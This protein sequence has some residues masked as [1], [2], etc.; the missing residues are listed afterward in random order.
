MPFFALSLVSYSSTVYVVSAIQ[1]I[2]NE[3]NKVYCFFLQKL[4]AGL[5]VVHGQRQSIG[6]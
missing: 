2:G 4:R 5:R 3:R 1:E 6:H